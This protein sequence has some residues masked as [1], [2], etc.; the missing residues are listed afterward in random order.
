MS[1]PKPTNGIFRQTVSVENTSTDG[2]GNL[3]TLLH[4]GVLLLPVVLFSWCW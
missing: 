2:P 4:M 1:I 3:D